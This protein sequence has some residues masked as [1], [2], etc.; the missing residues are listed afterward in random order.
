M[1]QPCPKCGYVYDRPARFC[2]QCGNQMY[3]ENEATSSPTLNYG[4]APPTYADQ[5]YVSQFA[6]TSMNPENQGVDTARFYRPPM[7]QQPAPNYGPPPA[8]SSKAAIWFVMISLF[9]VAVMAVGGIVF[10]TFIN[11][12]RPSIETSVDQ[13]KEDIRTQIQDEIARAQEEAQRAQEEAQRAQEEAAR[14]AREAGGAVAPPPPPP[15]PAAP[16]VTS[17]DKYKY[18]KADVKQSANFLGNEI[19]KMSTSDSPA[20]V[21]DFYQ[22]LA[23][24]P[25]FTNKDAVDGETFVFQIPGSPSIMITISPDEDAPGKTQIAVFRTRFQIPKISQ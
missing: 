20:T 9:L 22:K 25:S 8:K 15:A 3:A 19:I 17:L 6:S 13:A 1:Q 10:F 7:G 12:N 21:K 24:Q 5:P 16:G 18:P 2:R 4:Q 11:K 23:G 14:I